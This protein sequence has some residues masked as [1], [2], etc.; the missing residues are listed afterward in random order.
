[1]MKLRA[2]WKGL[3]I[4]KLGREAPERLNAVGRILGEAAA[5][6]IT[7]EVKRRIPSKGGWYSIY[8]AAIEAKET[9]E[10]QW[11]VDGLADVAIETVPANE[12]LLSFQGRD[13]FSAVLA[14]YN[15][16]PID[17]IP[18]T[19]KGYA[20]E[21]ILRAA[22][23]SEIETRREYLVPLLK[24]ITDALTEEGASVGSDADLVQINGKVYADIVYLA[25]R[26]EHGYHG[27]P[28]IPHWSLALSDARKSLGKWIA[29][30]VPQA[31]IQ[32]ALL[33]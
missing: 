3:D 28:H 26:L 25:L 8:K 22:E 23:F 9:G 5:E 32:K 4:Q 17:L 19:D 18:P 13:R 21:P 7:R 33:E 30:D 16:W 6:R 15:P 20:D 14:P 12:T 11:T 24:V 31:R 2:T 10:L 29:Q 1:M 27:F